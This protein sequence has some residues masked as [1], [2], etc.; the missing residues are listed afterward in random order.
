MEQLSLNSKT[1]IFSAKNVTKYWKNYQL[2]SNTSNFT[3]P[4][5]PHNDYSIFSQDENG[6]YLDKIDGEHYSKLL[7][8]G[9]E[10]EW[11]KPSE[12][13]GEHNRVLLFEDKIEPNDIKQG[14]VGDCYFVS[15]LAAIS[16]FPNLIYQIFRTKEI[17]PKGFYEIIL[18][19]DGEWQIVFVDDYFP[20]TKGTNLLSFAGSVG[21]ELWVLLL[22]KAWAKV[23]GGY[24]N[25]H[26]GSSKDVFLVYTGFASLFLPHY[27]LPIDELWNVIK[28]ADDSNKIMCAESRGHNLGNEG[29]VAHHVYSLI[30]AKSKVQDGQELRLL[31][32]RNPWGFLEWNGHWSDSSPLWTEELKQYFQVEVKDDGIF[33]MNLN[34]YNLMFD[35]THICHVMY[36]SNVKSFKVNSDS[37]KIPQIFNLTITEPAQV[38]IS[39]VSKNWRFNR[40]LKGK[41]RPFTL[42][43]AKYNQETSTFSQLL[44]EYSTF[45]ELESSR[46]LT[47]GLYT[48]WVYCDYNHCQYPK[49]EFYSVIF[50]SPAKYRVNQIT[51]TNF[52]I[53]KEM[54]IG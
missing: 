18:F 39:I 34:D 44:G 54:I 43:I 28:M 52:E 26:G 45:C 7:N 36:N 16:E 15:A 12:I 1:R 17:N 4:Y 49:P 33:Y 5:F 10:Y 13:F 38:S 41:T 46:F 23:N 2:T 27:G 40:E 42:F 31:K 21:N 20:V 8:D 24:S 30:S 9:R 19:I 47:E 14:G 6:E 25:I 51:D 29:I 50:F 48:F 35:A 37:I 53:I 32:L 22:E 3:D 11:K